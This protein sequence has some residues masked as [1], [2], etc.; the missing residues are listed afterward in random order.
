M[1]KLGIM[2]KMSLKKDTQCHENTTAICGETPTDDGCWP[3]GR[4]AV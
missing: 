3:T 1:Q 4:A 2:G